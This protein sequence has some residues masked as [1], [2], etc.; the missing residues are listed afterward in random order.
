MAHLDFGS[1]QTMGARARSGGRKEGL[2]CGSTAASLASRG[3]GSRDEIG[4]RYGL[5]IQYGS[6]EAL[7][8]SFLPRTSGGQR[9]ESSTCRLRPDTF[10]HT[11]YP[12]THGLTRPA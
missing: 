5:Q 3:V 1:A 4:I 8:R 2:I 11:D 9:A 12:T 10:P 7:I 6:R